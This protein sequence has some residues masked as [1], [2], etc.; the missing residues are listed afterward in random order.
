MLFA[1]AVVG[2]ERVTLFFF[3][4][5]SN[6]STMEAVQNKTNARQNFRGQSEFLSTMIVSN[7]HAPTPK[8]FVYGIIFRSCIFL[9]LAARACAYFFLCFLVFFCCRRPATPGLQCAGGSGP[10][11]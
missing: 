7:G 8:A 11:L 2:L 1:L 6:H 4:P 10:A 5:R 9:L 3:G